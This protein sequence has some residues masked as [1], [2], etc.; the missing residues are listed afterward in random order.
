[1]GIYMKEANM[2][3]H[4]HVHTLEYTRKNLIKD[5]KVI[6]KRTLVALSSLREKRENIRNME[7]E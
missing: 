7:L 5:A 4:T 6:K 1:M 2:H 3:K